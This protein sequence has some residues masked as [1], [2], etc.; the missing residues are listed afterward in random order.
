MALSSTLFDYIEAND[1][2]SH[3]LLLIDGYHEA[4]ANQT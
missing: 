2:Q 1:E 3:L 4:M